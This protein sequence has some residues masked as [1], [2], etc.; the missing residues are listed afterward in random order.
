MI[1]TGYAGHRLVVVEGGN[2]KDALHFNV[3]EDDVTIRPE[4]NLKYVH[5]NAVTPQPLRK[6]IQ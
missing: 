3:D 4:G 1:P 2:G 6:Q 5:G